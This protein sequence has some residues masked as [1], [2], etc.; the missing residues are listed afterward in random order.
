M[1]LISGYEYTRGVQGSVVKGLRSWEGRKL[2]L[3]RDRQGKLV[4]VT[5]GVTPSP[6]VDVSWLKAASEVYDISPDIRDYVIN[7]VPA[8]NADIPNRNLDAFPYSEL[9]KFRPVLGR[10][11]YMSYRGKATN[12]D[13]NNRDPKVAKGVLFD[14]Y[15]KRD[16]AGYYHVHVVAGWCRQKDAKLSQRILDKKDAGYSMACLIGGAKCSICGY[17]SQGNVTCKHIN[18]GVGKGTLVNGKLAYELLCD[19]NF[20]ELSHVEDRADIDCVAG[21]VNG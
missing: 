5:A 15:M 16:E 17:F 18:G 7:E 3:D 14:A 8:N 13:H 2:G 19:L 9:V 21:W 1:P 12:A 10:V 11:A 20:H 6:V 4:M